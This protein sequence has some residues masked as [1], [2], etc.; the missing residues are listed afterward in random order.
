MSRFHRIYGGT[1]G[2]KANNYTQGSK[3]GI[4]GVNEQ[5]ILKSQNQ[6]SSVVGQSENNPAS[7]ADAIYSANP[8]LNS[9]LYYINSNGTDTDLLWCELNYGGS[10]RSYV[11]IFSVTNIY[12]T[13]ANWWLDNYMNSTTFEGSGTTL[14]SWTSLVKMN[15]KWNSWNRLTFNELLIIENFTDNVGYRSYI[16]SSNQNMNYYLGVTTGGRNA[17]GT[18]GISGST[19]S[20]RAFNTNN[21][22]YNNALGDD[23]GRIVPAGPSSEASGGFNTRVDGGTGYSWKGNITRNDSN[24]HFGSNGATGNHSLW[25]LGRI[26]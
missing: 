3:S 16:H 1:I 13:T 14:S 21:I 15:G 23:G 11:L 18:G 20:M 4:F 22:Y 17:S 19:G 5:L 2:K 8:N 25:F 7:S 26:N 12:G 6:W 9:G 10:G 24:R